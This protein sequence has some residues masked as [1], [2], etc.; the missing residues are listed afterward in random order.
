MSFQNEIG[1]EVNLGA[2]FRADVWLFSETGGFIIEV[3]KK[4][5]DTVTG[6]LSSY[7]IHYEK[8]GETTDHQAIVFG[9]KIH[10]SISKAKD[11]WQ[12]SLR[13]QIK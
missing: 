11:V 1:F 7:E 13:N 12:Q 9:E 4:N 10:I 8:I 3:D 2:S 6:A 5:L